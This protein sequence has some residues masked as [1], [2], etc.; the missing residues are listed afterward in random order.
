M[1]AISETLDIPEVRKDVIKQALKFET[2]YSFP[3]AY[4]ISIL[5]KIHMIGGKN[6]DLK[7]FIKTI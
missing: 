5:T 3:I 4:F 1:H 7:D 2:F 6:D